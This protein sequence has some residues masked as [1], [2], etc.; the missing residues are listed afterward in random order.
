MIHCEDC[1][2]FT[3]KFDIDD[4]GDEIQ[5]DFC[6]CSAYCAPL[7]VTTREDCPYYQN[8]GR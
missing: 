1:I 6:D 4:F 2:Y 5:A 3:E 8:C 7:D